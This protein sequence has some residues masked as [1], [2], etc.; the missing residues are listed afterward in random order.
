MNKLESKE[1]YLERILM[2]SKKNGSVRS[3]DIAHDMGFS[4]PSVSVAMKKLRE[5][6]LINVDKDGLISLTDEGRLIAER[7][8]ERHTVLKAILI[9]IGVDEQVA[10]DDACKVEHELSEETFS[11][12]REVYNNGK[13]RN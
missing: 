3:I 11:K 7:T 1:D 2:L 4:K 6:K 8:Y 10:E 5:L 12:I 9:H 13:Y